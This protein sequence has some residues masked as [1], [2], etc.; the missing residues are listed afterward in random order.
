[1]LVTVAL[2]GVL[3]AMAVPHF[4]TLRERNQVVS[5][6]ND[7]VASLLMAR[8]EAINQEATVT[9]QSDD[10]ETASWTIVDADDDI[11]VYHEP[12]RN[13]SITPYG[14]VAEVSYLSSGRS[15]G[16]AFT[17][18]DYFNV[19]S[20]DTARKVCMSAIGRPFVSREGNCP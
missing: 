6:A 10:W 9:V 19:E 14:N 17:S 2:L 7:L 18:A 15:A 4:K 12:S 5:T 13:V 3:V 8:S 11:I 16:T 1:M 20:G